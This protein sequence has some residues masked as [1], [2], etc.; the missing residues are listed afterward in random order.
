VLFLGA[1]VGLL[2]ALWIATREVYFVGVDSQQGSVVTVY[3]GLPYD[4]P[5][6]IKLYSVVQRSG[7]TLQ[8][9]PAGRRATFTDHQLRSRDDAE[10]LVEALED[11]EIS[12]GLPPGS[13]QAV[14]LA[15]ARGAV[16]R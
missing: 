13:R 11:G 6:G 12:A 15:G 9:V 3:R 5:L 4:L 7:V 8:S 16:N 10:N 1:L 14:A 2:L